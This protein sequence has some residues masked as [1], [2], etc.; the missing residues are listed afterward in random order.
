[1]ITW[2]A[3]QEDVWITE[4]Y[5]TVRGAAIAHL[6]GSAVYESIGP[7][8]TMNSASHLFSG[9][10][11]V[12]PA[13]RA[14]VAHLHDRMRAERPATPVLNDPRKTLLR[15]ELL[16]HLES[17]GLNDFRVWRIDEVEAVDRFPVF[18]RQELQHDG[19][20]TQL[21]HDRDTLRGAIRALVAR[22]FPRDD[23]M[24]VQFYDVSQPDGYYRKY[25]AFKLGKRV[26]AAYV[27]VGQ[28]WLVKSEHNV[29]TVEVAEEAIEYIACN[30]HRE[31]LEKVFAASGVDYGR[32]DYGVREGRPQ[33]WEINLNP[34]VGPGRGDY[35][36][37]DSP[38]GRRIRE[39][40][41]IHHE[42]LRDAFRELAEATATPPLTVEIPTELTAAVKREREDALCRERRVAAL[43][44]VY[45]HPLV[46]SPL[47]WIYRLL[48]PRR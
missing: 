20:L 17:T 43:Q 12:T 39:A 34:T 29:S 38:A 11:R 30:P 40:R 47:R 6:I 26:L 35:S 41:D 13:G 25:S 48:V 42:E 15:F 31:W 33:A 19:A 32:L 3:P 46:G 36:R 2:W 27:D 18:V 24:I 45:H 28:Q 21:L 22:G 16:R 14:I 7:E 1:M 8:V 44:S 37:D 4:W 23:L 9:L 10:D 5:R